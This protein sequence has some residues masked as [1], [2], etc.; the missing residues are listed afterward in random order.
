MGTAQCVRACC[1]EVEGGQ[2]ERQEDHGVRGRTIPTTEV[3]CL[4]AV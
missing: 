4:L 2:R 1:N 3:I